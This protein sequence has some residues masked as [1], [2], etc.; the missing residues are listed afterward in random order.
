MLDPEAEASRIAAAREKTRES[1]LHALDL[2]TRKMLNERVA[3]A[4]SKGL[5]L[6]IVSKSWNDK[7][8]A[9]LAESRTVGS[10]LYAMLH[11]Q[12]ESE[13]QEAEMRSEEGETESE[14]DKTANQ[15]QKHTESEAANT[16]NQEQNG[17]C[18]AGDH[19]GTLVQRLAPLVQEFERRLDSEA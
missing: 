4:R 17:A 12:V 10:P 5:D 13:L 15:E 14:A 3:A 1:L 2:A 18:A 11:T 9:L 6:K 19:G 7:R 8:R 16:V